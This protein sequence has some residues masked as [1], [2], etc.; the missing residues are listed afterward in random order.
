MQAIEFETQLKDGMIKLPMPYQHWQEGQQVKVILLADENPA[1]A[2]LNQGK[3]INRHAGK[4]TL[5]QEPLAF[6]EGIRDE[7]S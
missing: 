2:A 6:Q 1:T 3:D 5:T 7:W 4:I